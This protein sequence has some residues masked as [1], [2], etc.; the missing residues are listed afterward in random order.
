MVDEAHLIPASGDGMYRRLAKTWRSA[1]AGQFRWSA[2]RPPFRTNSGSLV[3]GDGR[4]FE[5]VAYEVE[6]L[7][8]IAEGYLAPIT[9]KATDAN[10]T[11]AA[12]PSAAASSSSQLRAAVDKAEVTK[13]AV[14]EI[15]AAGRDRLSGSCSRPAYSMAFISATSCASTASPRRWCTAR[16]RDT[17]GMLPLR[18]TNPVQLGALSA[19]AF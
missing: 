13:A 3:E 8:M 5:E 1:T 11:P 9:T 19:T 7:R 17:S 16:C 15:V 2:S 6:L 18:R 10:S 12:S 4:V 14:A